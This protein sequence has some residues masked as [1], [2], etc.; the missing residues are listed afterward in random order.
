MITD[1]RARTRGRVW[2]ST[3]LRRRPDPRRAARPSGARRP[4]LTLRADGTTSGR[5]RA[6]FAVSGSSAYRP[7]RRRT[8]SPATSRPPAV[9]ADCRACRSRLVAGWL[10]SVGS[11]EI[12]GIAA[13]RPRPLVPWRSSWRRS[14]LSPAASRASAPGCSRRRTGSTAE[15]TRARRARLR[16]RRQAVRRLSVTRSPPPRCSRAGRPHRRSPGSRVGSWWHW[17]AT[18]RAHAAAR[19]GRAGAVSGA[20]RLTT[21]SSRG[22]ARRRPTLERAA[23]AVARLSPPPVALRRRRRGCRRVGARR[24]ARGF[25]RS[26]RRAA[27]SLGGGCSP[28]SPSPGSRPP[29][30]WLD[31]RSSAGGSAFVAATAPRAARGLSARLRGPSGRARPR[32]CGTRARGRA[33]GGR[34]EPEARQRVEQGRDPDPRLEPGEVDADADVRALG[35]RQVPAGVGAAEVEG[36]GIGEH[37]RIAVGRRQRDPHELAAPDPRRRP[38]ERPRVA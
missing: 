25:P 16:R 33:R 15:L 37:R 30:C 14:G 29:R 2:R 35:E 11:V 38:A 20:S 18:A 22:R 13:S 8:N 12:G 10:G 32:A 36:I 27:V 9:P 31:S 24:S 21:T 1:Y 3:R 23:R 26:G 7:R 6:R 5:G 19:V 17:D 34:V 4:R 28:A